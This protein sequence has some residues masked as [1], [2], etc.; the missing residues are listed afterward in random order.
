M[1]YQLEVMLLWKILSE[2]TIRVFIGAALP[3]SIRMSKVE[4]ELEQFS[5]LFVISKLFAVIGSQGM[6]LVCHRK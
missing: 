4:F 1:R 3:G 5:D 6:N 2:Q